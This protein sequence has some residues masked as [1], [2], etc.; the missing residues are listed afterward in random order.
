M[1]LKKI[2]AFLILSVFFIPVSFVFE[3]DLK[4]EQGKN[5]LF[6]FVKSLW[7]PFFKT[8]SI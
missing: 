5:L 6:D 7:S 4:L 1:N 8:Y 2:V 3:E